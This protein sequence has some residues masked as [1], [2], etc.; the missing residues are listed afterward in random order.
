MSLGVDSVFLAQIAT[1][2]YGQ[3]GLLGCH[4]RV[5][6]GSWP[7]NNYGELA[8]RVYASLV[9]NLQEILSIQATVHGALVKTVLPVP[10]Q[11]AYSERKTAVGNVPGQALPTQI[12][13]L[14]TKYAPIGGRH[15][16][17]RCYVPFPAEDDN[18]PANEPSPTE[19]YVSKLLLF[20]K[21][22]VQGRTWI[23]TEGA[24]NITVVPVIFHKTLQSSTDVTEVAA[25][26]YWATQR[27]RGQTNRVDEPVIP[28]LTR[29]PIL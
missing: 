9:V 23:A 12:C 28:D 22:F 29:E 1:Y 21:D 5:T 17:G 10:E 18:D 11:T 15:G 19:G 4:F 13:G 16:Y 6:A 20:A 3:N 27:R 8:E 7:D 24:G 2:A 14:F 25:N 26:D